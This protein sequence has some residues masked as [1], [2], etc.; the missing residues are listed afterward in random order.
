MD[1][2]RMDGPMDGGMDCT[3]YLSDERLASIEPAEPVYP[4]LDLLLCR[5]K[6]ARAARA[7]LRL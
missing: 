6:A 4:P 2:E 3:G 1:V 5:A 7:G